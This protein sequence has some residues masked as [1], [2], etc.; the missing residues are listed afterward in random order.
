MLD[1]NLMMVSLILGLFFS[2]IDIR[3]DILRILLLFMF[4]LGFPN[5]LFFASL[6]VLGLALIV[7]F[8]ECFSDWDFFTFFLVNQSSSFSVDWFDSDFALLDSFFILS[9]LIPFLPF[10]L[11]QLIQ[12]SLLLFLLSPESAFFLQSLFMFFSAFGSDGI[13]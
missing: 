2:S 13:K 8:S 12:F 5:Q 6:L 9:F 11:L 1:F 10:F 3:L 7:R 4:V